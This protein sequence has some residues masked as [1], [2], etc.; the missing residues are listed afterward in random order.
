MKIC[1]QCGLHYQT[2]CSCGD[3]KPL[4]RI[5]SAGK[6]TSMAELNNWLNVCFTNEDVIFSE[7]VKKLSK[8]EIIKLYNLCQN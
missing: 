4:E 8:Q 1:R 5:T 6:T 2:A 7:P 3:F